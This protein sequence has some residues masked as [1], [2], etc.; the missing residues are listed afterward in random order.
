MENK[1]ENEK[2]KDKAI[3][4][5]RKMCSK[6]IKLFIETLISEGVSKDQ[7]ARALK[8]TETE[9]GAIVDFVND[10]CIRSRQKDDKH[11]E[12][13]SMRKDYLTRLLVHYLKEKGSIANAIYFPRQSFKAFTDAI[14]KLLGDSLI[15]EKQLQ[16]Y[17]IVKDYQDES[18]LINW[19]A[20]FVDNRAQ[21]IAWDVLS[22]ISMAMSGVT[23]EW[24]K[25]YIIDYAKTQG[26]FYGEG[27][28][29]Y[30]QERLESIGKTFRPK[31]REI[32][33]KRD[34]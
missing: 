12:Y 20:V 6:S 15:E 34:K 32:M 31:Q 17:A 27:V 4:F 18:G 10:E 14:R 11:K 30:V 2:E 13:E 33:P 8:R 26:D 16:C 24:F 19:D 21:Q 25:G 5:C 23:G 22:R 29:H 3:G 28:A 1:K 7:L 9:L